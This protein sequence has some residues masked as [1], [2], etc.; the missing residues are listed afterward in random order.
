V[1]ETAGTI[2]FKGNNNAV[3]A[4]YPCNTSPGAWQ[5]TSG[6]NSMLNLVSL[7]QNTT[8]I[9]FTNNAE[10]FQGSLWTQPTSGMTFVKNGVVVEGPMSIGSFDATFNNADLIPFPVIKNMPLGAPIPPNAGVT[11]GSLVYLK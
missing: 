11:F 7:A 10:I 2:T 6:N 3:C 5:G 4:E 8:A 1:I 9:T